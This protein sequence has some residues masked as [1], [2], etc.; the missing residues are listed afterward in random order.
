M[1]S[2]CYQDVLQAVVDDYCSKAGLDRILVSRGAETALRRIMENE[3][4]STDPSL[5]SLRRAVIARLS[6]CAKVMA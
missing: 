1:S 4:A 6:Y 2:K 3:P 5:P